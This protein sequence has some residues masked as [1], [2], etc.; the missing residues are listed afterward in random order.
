MNLLDILP[1]RC[2]IG[3]NN[4]EGEA[5]NLSHLYYF[6]KLAELQHYTRAAEALHITQ[7]TLSAAV[8]SLEQELGV[9]LFQKDGRNMRLTKYGREFSE[10]VRRALDELDRGIAVMTEYGDKKK[11]VVH[12]GTIFTIEGDFLPRTII[13]CQKQ[14]QSNTQFVVHQGLTSDIAARVKSGEYD[15]GF[16]SY[17]PD[18]PSL[19]FLPVVAQS[20]VAAVHVSHPLAA[21]NE[22]DTSALA[23]QPIISYNI[24]TQVGREV[25]ALLSAHD[26]TARQIFDSEL[27]LSS[28]LHENPDAVA[29]VL[30]TQQVL[31]DPDIHCLRLRGEERNCHFIC[32]T[33]DPNAYRTPAASRFLEYAGGRAE[34]T[35]RQQALFCALARKKKEP[36]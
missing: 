26:V 5:V 35:E 32:M 19:T 36:D 3:M 20:Y 25:H 21:L 22:I 15:V 31:H 12:I 6:R 16:C 24:A 29:V 14:T 7:P 30:S 11:G 34:L 33:Y 17:L 1:V 10:Y 27:F 23:G 4:K 2:Y 28:L 8:A 13:G 18:E 9:S